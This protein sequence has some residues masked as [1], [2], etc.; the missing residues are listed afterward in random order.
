MKMM[1]KKLRSLIYAGVGLILCVLLCGGIG[2]T[3]QAAEIK[4]YEGFTYTENGSEITITG[5]TGDKTELVIPGEIDG[6]KVTDIGTKAFYEYSSLTSVIIPE[7]VTNIGA[8]AFYNCNSLT[9]AT[10]PKSVTS[11][12][13][14]AF[15]YCGGLTSIVVDKEN[16]YYDSRNNCNAI[17]ETSSNTLVRGCKNTIIPD[18]VTSVK[19]GAFCGCS[20]LTSITIPAGVTRIEA[21]AFKGCSGLTSIVVDKENKYFD[22]R[23]NCNAIIETESNTLVIGCK[24]TTIPADVTSIGGCA[25][26]DCSSL[27]SIT[28]PKGVTS[29]WADAFAGC[30]G[31]TSITISAGVTSIGGEAFSDCSSLTSIT[32]PA[33]VTSIG[34]GAFGGCSGLTSITIPASVTGLGDYLFTG[35][36]SLT[37]IKVDKENKYYDSR[38]NSNAIIA[39]ESNTLVYGCKNTT[40]PAS[41]TRLGDYA[42]AGCSGLTSITIPQ[43]VTSIGYYAFANCSGLTS[44]TIPQ[45]VTSIGEC[46]FSNC[47]DLVFYCYEDST[48]Y[49]YA[50]DN[51][52]DISVKLIGE[53]VTPGDTSGDDKPTPTPT[54]EPTPEPTPTPTPEKPT[55]IP[56]KKGATLTV[57]SKKIKVK[58]TS[59]SKKNPT[60]T[61]TKFTDKK[62][63]K[64]II[65]ATVKVKGVTYKVTAI[66][67]KA[68]KGNK[69]LTTVTIGSNVTKIGKEAFSGCKNLKK[70]TVTAGK[71]KTISKN[72]FKGINK[73]AT[74]TVKGTKKAKTALKKQLKK[75]SI[76][77]VKTWKIK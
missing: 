77:Y 6:K 11:I 2:M 25:F 5:Y 47:H 27:T 73:K 56:A 16:K 3:A 26:Y 4:T 53:T 34:N 58:V 43:G 29:I 57:S 22:S 14:L 8:N 62:V 61:I 44:I 74:I 32:L 24:N 31:L 45:S 55:A 20:G 54:P 17:I 65:P 7:G 63:K 76:G 38:N 19:W 59:S 1:Q 39:T 36:S 41:V 52:F 33:S 35:C 68:F 10:I 51:S 28:I 64:L 23:N 40:I 60:V 49:E 42:F 37:S 21:T 18:S 48:A 72:A 9:S 46:A 75:K 15:G 12:G 67:D 30:S 71:L 70:I 69:K 13:F 66:S 50:M